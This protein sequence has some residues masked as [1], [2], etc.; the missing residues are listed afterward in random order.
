MEHLKTCE[1]SRLLC[2]V[3]AASLTLAATLNIKIIGFH[4]EGRHVLYVLV[5]SYFVRLHWFNLNRVQNRKE[6]EPGKC[7]LTNVPCAQLTTCKTSQS[8][9]ST[10]HNLQKRNDASVCCKQHIYSKCKFSILWNG[11]DVHY[12]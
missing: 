10:I 5:F 8:R 12:S 3:M 6:S 1:Y 9:Q 11:L 7:R 4:D 2:P